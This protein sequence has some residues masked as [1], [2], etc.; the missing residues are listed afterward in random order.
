M[1][2][3][4]Q[5]HIRCHQQAESQRTSRP[6]FRPQLSSLCAYFAKRYFQRKRHS[7]QVLLRAL[8]KTNHSDFIHITMSTDQLADILSSLPP[9]QRAALLDKPALEAPP[10]VGSVLD[11][12]PNRDSMVRG[13][14]ILY[15]ILTTLVI[16]LRGYC[17][18]CVVRKVLLEDCK[19]G[20]MATICSGADDSRSRVLWLCIAPLDACVL[21]ISANLRLDVGAIRRILFC[22]LRPHYQD[23]NVRTPV[24][25]PYQ[26]SIHNILGKSVSLWCGQM[27]LTFKA[28]R[29]CVLSAQVNIIR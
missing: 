20:R 4:Y 17:K 18:V 28:P 7:K 6:A 9:D 27:P 11:D 29:I 14:L 21:L 26:G 23:W 24:G 15:L 22:G 16:I 3:V 8:S 2:S 10:G 25:Y 19:I 5:P 13:V 1:G 12:P